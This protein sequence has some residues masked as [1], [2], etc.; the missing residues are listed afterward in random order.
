[1]TWPND[2]LTRTVTGTYL[3][4][5]G[6]AAKGRVIFTPSTRVVDEDDAV[7]IED[8]ITASLDASGSFQVELPAT[9]NKLLSPQEWVYS[10]NVRLYG[11]KPQKFYAKL[12]YGDGTSV[13]LVSDVSLI[14]ISTLPSVPSGGSR[15]PI[16]P[17]GPGV[18]VGDGA[19]ADD[20]GQD[21]D[22]Y[23]D[24]INGF[25]YGPKASGEWPVDPFY[26]PAEQTPSI[27]FVFTQAAPAS[28]WVVSHTLGGRPSVTVVDSGGTVVIG[29][30]TYNSDTQVTL[31]FTAPFS[32]FAYLT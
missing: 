9:D 23:I 12:P 16:G 17:R 10:V 31:S 30:I 2:V 29:E 5:T 4:A 3:T 13:D 14:G 21:G 28:T 6:Q 18:L 27:R 8:P 1:V 7:V 32:G 25:Y 26:T 19:P 15:G 11:V 20:I 22:L 24:S